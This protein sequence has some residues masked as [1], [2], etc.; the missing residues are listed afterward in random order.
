MQ[1]RW[2]YLK[3]WLDGFIEGWREGCIVG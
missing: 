1:Y 2:K 3:G